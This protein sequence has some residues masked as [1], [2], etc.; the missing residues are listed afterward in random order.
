M[1]IDTHAHLNFREF[2][3]DYQ[4][5]IK[6][7]FESGIEGIINVGSN[8]KNSYRAIAIAKRYKKG[9]WAA[10]GA[11]PIHI[12]GGYGLF[13]QDGTRPSLIMDDYEME[14]YG[15]LVSIDSFE[16]AIRE[17]KVVAIGEI[18]LDYF[19]YPE[20]IKRGQ[21]IN[22]EIQ[23]DCFSLFLQMSREAKLP[24][25][26]HSRESMPDFLKIL[27]KQHNI[28]GVVHCFPGGLDEAKKI[29]E[30][31]LY[32]S[33]TGLITFARDWDRVIKYIP[34]ERFLIETDCPFMTPEPYR[35]KRNEP[36]YVTEVAKKIAELKNLSLEKVARKTTE[37]ARDL[38]GL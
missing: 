23:K 21:R 31:G 7:A 27:Q 28:K 22:K 29:L 33:F 8:L 25:I 34:L 13:T 20:K 38:F 24:V 16:E 9:V 35:G 30:L 32:I 5:V 6:R 14:T 3:E 17:N 11:H 18:G 37:N 2:E 15:E 12:V 26:M 36:A 4:E 19:V 1:F 10:V